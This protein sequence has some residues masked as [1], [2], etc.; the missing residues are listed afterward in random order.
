M[1]SNVRDAFVIN[2]HTR[3]RMLLDVSDEQILDELRFYVYV[4]PHVR[5]TPD[6]VRTMANALLLRAPDADY[7]Q[8]EQ[9][10]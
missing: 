2:P 1:H 6:E 9:F 3:I 8:V 10:L 5:M 7:H 4:V